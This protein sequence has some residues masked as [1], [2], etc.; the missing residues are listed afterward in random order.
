MTDSSL[1]R[2]LQ[3]SRRQGRAYTVQRRRARRACNQARNRK[4]QTRA[5]AHGHRR[6]AHRSTSFRNRRG[7]R[8]CAVSH[9]R[10]RNRARPAGEFPAPRSVETR[11]CKPLPQIDGHAVVLAGSCS[12][13]TRRQ[14]AYMNERCDSLMLD[15]LGLARERR[16]RVDGSRSGRFRAWG[17][18]RC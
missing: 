2:V 16:R 11:G 15:P 7:M 17:K 14:V 6:C 18:N 4:A 13:A 10:I 3:R 12:A 8:G 9:W 5:H 1:V